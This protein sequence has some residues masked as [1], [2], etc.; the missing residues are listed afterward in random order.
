MGLLD[1]I[2]GALN[3]AVEGTKAAYA[4]ASAMDLETLCAAM[5]EV[6]SPSATMLGYQQAFRQKLDVLTDDELEGFYDYIKREGTIFKAHPGRSS[7]EDLLVERN[8]YSRDE[9]DGTIHKNFR[10]FR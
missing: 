2:K 7:V 6:K 3:N 5:K 1:K 9:E 10:L 8:I 4:E